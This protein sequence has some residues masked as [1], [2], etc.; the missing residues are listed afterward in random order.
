VL[1]GFNWTDGSVLPE[2][3]VASEIR[4]AILARYRPS[5][6]MLDVNGGD[7]IEWA[8]GYGSSAT[9]TMFSIS[10]YQRELPPLR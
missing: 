2:D 8:C 7:P 4:A 10:G 6:E 5:K 1:V 9:S 3:E